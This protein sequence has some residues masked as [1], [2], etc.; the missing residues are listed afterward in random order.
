MKDLE[1]LVPK[2]EKQQRTLCG[3]IARK[4]NLVLKLLP[5]VEAS[6]PKEDSGRIR[7]LLNIPT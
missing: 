5:K 1:A 2:L 7:M 6:L 3:R 4:E